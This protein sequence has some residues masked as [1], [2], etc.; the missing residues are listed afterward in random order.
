MK[1][2]KKKTT[3]PTEKFYEFPIEKTLDKV[4]K[5]YYLT[6][7]IKGSQKKL[8]DLEVMVDATFDNFGDL[9]KHILEESKKRK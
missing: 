6:Y 2:S 8:K 5:D 1:N 4:G 7:K 3:K 9:W